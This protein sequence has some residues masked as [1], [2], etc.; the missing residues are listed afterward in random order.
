MTEAEVMAADVRRYTI[1]LND[2]LRQATLARLVVRL[3]LDEIDIST[4]EE[5]HL[6]L[7]VVRTQTLQPLG[8][9]A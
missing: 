5:P 8:G 9:P 6:R 7:L 2:A 4:H 3:E 1:A